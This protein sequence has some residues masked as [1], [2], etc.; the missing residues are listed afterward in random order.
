M[1]TTHHISFE[2]LAGNFADVFNKVREEHKAVVVEYK[3]GE[4]IL[5]KPV[6]PG[7]EIVR[8]GRIRTKADIEAFRAAA[9]SWKDEDVDTLLK[10]VYE[11][12]RN[13]SRP[14]VEL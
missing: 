7:K 12:R 13:S 3:T 5:I 6:T 1:N 4:K 8:R 11:S 10:N 9:G 2:E 14:A